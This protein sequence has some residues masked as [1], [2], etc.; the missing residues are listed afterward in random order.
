MN[1][2]VLIA[3]NKSFD[4]L[5]LNEIQSDIGQGKI[6]IS[7]ANPLIKARMSLIGLSTSDIIFFLDDDVKY[8]KGLIPYL[9]QFMDKDVGACQ[10]VCYPQGLG[11]E[12]DLAIY[13][14][15]YKNT[16]LKSLI[17]QDGIS[18]LYT[19]N[20]LIKSSLVKDWQGNIKASGFEDLSLT[21]H[22]QNKGFKCLRIKTPFLTWHQYSWI[23]ILRNTIKWRNGY[24]YCMGLKKFIS[25]LIKL[26][27]HI[28]KSIFFFSSNYRFRI[29][30]IWI[31]S[32][33]IFASLLFI[34]KRGD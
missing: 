23:K 34:I 12:W 1:V 19:H 9:L 14:Y 6:I 27:I 21:K 16:P 24:F 2:D 29:F 22:I 30:Q 4:M 8:T 33:S 17:R 13:N 26:N 20:T 28:I 7:W 32:C 15:F 18:R 3:T 10:G 25:R 31:D 11:S 5:N